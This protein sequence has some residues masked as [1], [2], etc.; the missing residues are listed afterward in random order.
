MYV[1]DAS[2]ALKWFVR[3][4]D[5]DKALALCEQALLGSLDM[6]APD[7]LLYEVANI[8]LRKIELTPSQVQNSIRQLLDTGISFSALDA[9]LIFRAIHV[10]GTTGA[11]VY[12]ASY[13]A[14]A[15]EVNGT[16][17]TADRR[18]AKLAESQADIRMLDTF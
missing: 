3:E 9:G 7:M 13:V 1:I 4:N 16:L 15:L 8:L 5:S 11:S 17:V 2:V 10:A 12:D 14:L 18:L 6:A